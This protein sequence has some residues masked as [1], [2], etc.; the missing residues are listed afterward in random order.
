MFNFHKKSKNIHQTMDHL[1]ILYLII[2]T[3][4]SLLALSPLSIRYIK[5]IGIVYF[6]SVFNILPPLSTL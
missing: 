3:V 5:K 2:P 1:E 6:I 4:N